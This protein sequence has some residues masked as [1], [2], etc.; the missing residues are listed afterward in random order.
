MM[1]MR[2]ILMITM[3]LLL[4]LLTGC[5]S[6]NTYKQAMAYFEQGNYTEAREEFLSLKHYKDAEAMAQKCQWLLSQPGDTLLF[7]SYEQDNDLENG[8]E[9]IEWLVLD[10]D[11]SRVLVISKYILDARIYGDSING[12]VY[13]A[14]SDLRTW[15]ND[16]FLH[17][18]FSTEEREW[19]LVT[20]MEN[21]P[22]ESR[23]END[24]K[25]P[26]ILP[27]ED[28]V[29]LLSVPEV[30]A[31][32]PDTQSRIAVPTAYAQA[33]E[34]RSGWWLRTR[35]YAASQMHL[36]HHD[37]MLLD[38]GLAVQPY[39]IRP[40]MWVDCSPGAE[41]PVE[42]MEPPTVPKSDFQAPT[43]ELD[44][45]PDMDITPG[46]RC[47]VTGNA[48]IAETEAGYYMNRG[49]FLFYADKSDLSNWVPVCNDATCNHDSGNFACNAYLGISSFWLKEDGI[50][51][52]SNS[53]GID[54]LDGYHYIRRNFDGSAPTTVYTCSE[55]QMQGP[56][57][58]TDAGTGDSYL[59]SYVFLL[60]DGSQFLRLVLTDKAG[61]RILFSETFPAGESGMEV[62][63]PEIRQLP[64]S[65]R[66]DA[67]IS[68]QIPLGELTAEEKANWESY[69][70]ILYY[71]VH[72][73]ELLPLVVPET[74]DIVGAFISGNHFFHYHVND[75]FY[76]MDLSTGEEV[77]IAHAAYENGYGLCLDGTI[78]VETTM[79][80]PAQLRDGVGANLR[81]YDGQQWHELQTQDNWTSDHWLR[82]W[83][84]ASD[85]L[86]FT[87]SDGRN[88]A[89][90]GGE[91]MTELAYVMLG[92][93]EIVPCDKSE[94]YP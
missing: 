39:G 69:T 10:R 55:Y 3:A 64:M 68:S 11:G 74:C 53:I 41:A 36:V 61:A 75:G 93:K 85:R 27:T 60:E 33:Q 43:G 49:S 24:E 50:Y 77:K 13:W 35:G 88:T 22:P 76:Y 2:R 25:H 31:Y 78:L 71:H 57:G 63:Y 46:E 62:P 73:G 86:L 52:H 72:D 15:L 59:N 23:R 20:T 48:R 87:V 18:A 28:R 4:L 9:D 40:A 81:Y 12:A 51:Y 5:Q 82:I 79:D 42:T 44:T 26:S 19:L 47:S 1:K 58:G 67:L 84:A 38:V 89:S 32:F 92:E 80:L 65:T 21:P 30:E 56:Y 94:F 90:D 70:D 91:R 83:A 34:V 45:A 6:G 54:H 37:G 29:F 7:G 17:T 16:T 66:G 14:I 8:P